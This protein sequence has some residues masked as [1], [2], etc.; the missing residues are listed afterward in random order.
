MVAPGKRLE[1]I[2][3]VPTEVVGVQRLRAKHLVLG[4]EV[5]LR[6]ALAPGREGEAAPFV[7]EMLELSYL[8]HPALPPVLDRGVFQGRYYYAVPLRPHMGLE[9]LVDEPEL[10][11]VPRVEMV[12]Q[13]AS[14]LATMHVVGIVPPA[15]DP[16][17]L[18]WD[19]AQGALRFRHLRLRGPG[20]PAY[21][22]GLSSEGRQEAGLTSARANV[23]QWAAL[24]YWL[25]A[26]GAGPCEGAGEPVPLATRS[27]AVHPDLARLV[28]ACIVGDDDE[29]PESGPELQALLRLVPG[30]LRAPPSGT[31]SGPM[32]APMEAPLALDVKTS[33][34]DLRASGRIP[35]LLGALDGKLEAV[36]E[37]LQAIELPSFEAP[38]STTRNLGIAAAM[39]LCLLG[40]LLVGSG[41]EAPRV[42]VGETDLT[43]L[44]PTVDE[45]A[46]D[47][48]VAS[49][50]A[51]R[52]VAREDFG[53]TW[54]VLRTLA[55]QSRLPEKLRDEARILAV[56]GRFQKDPEG[57][58]AELEAMLDELRSELGAG[59]AG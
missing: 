54:R 30:A 46:R 50:V 6:V 43:R 52:S 59:G 15:P 38:E 1:L 18:C 34:H 13:L 10:G 16:R 27:E 33:L 14:A 21:A 47:P 22:G 48:Y 12:R 5:E 57:A 35:R 9:A 32:A 7:Q 44:G 4:R 20:E 41:G 49:L 39:G 19:E 51:M 37:R 29:R 40:G 28:D 25:L 24:A 45:L 36:R 26:R 56:H 53:R 3:E 11:V 55:L 23:L 31:P 8:D 17:E 42:K 2:G 58:C